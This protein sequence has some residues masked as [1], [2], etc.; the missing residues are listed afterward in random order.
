MRKILKVMLTEDGSETL[1]ELA[2]I[3]RANNC[4]VS[5]V[6]KNGTQVIERLKSGEQPDVMAAEL[7]GMKRR[8]I[9]SAVFLLPLFYLSMG[10]ML[11]APLPQFSG[12]TPAGEAR[13]TR[14]DGQTV[15]QV[16]LTYPG[17]V[18]TAVR[19][20]SAAPL[21]LRN[22]LSIQ[23]RSDLTVM[24]LPATLAGKGS[25]H[26]LYFSSEF[27]AYSLYAPNAT[28]EEF[29]SLLRQITQVK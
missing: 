3:L 26:C 1:H 29:L 5:T 20:A 6:F 16:T 23:S 14:H 21:L 22:E 28:E 25:S 2:G 19:P 18:I 10:H 17:L 27:A 9:W 8:L 15:R 12:H 4:E 7:A 24:N 11:G 13:N